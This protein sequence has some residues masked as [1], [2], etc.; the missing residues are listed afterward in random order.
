VTN[1]QI[2]FIS[3]VG[4]LVVVLALML[5]RIAAYALWTRFTPM[6]RFEAG[7][8]DQFEQTLREAERVLASDR[9][10]RVSE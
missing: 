4:P 2:V 3:I 9:R 7:I 5:A 8:Y 1:S 6:A 10:R